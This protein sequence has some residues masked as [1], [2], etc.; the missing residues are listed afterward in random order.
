MANPISEIIQL[1]GP[2]D[3]LIRAG[4]AALQNGAG[5]VETLR[6][7]DIIAA[8]KKCETGV[9][10]LTHLERWAE[11]LENNEL[12]DYSPQESE[13]ISATLFRLSSSEI[14]SPLTDTLV[15]QLIH[16]LSDK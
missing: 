14:N 15:C 16:D 10:S 4:W 1:R 7:D 13:L 11:F 2:A 6:V 5:N 8:L 3:S 12:V 9:L